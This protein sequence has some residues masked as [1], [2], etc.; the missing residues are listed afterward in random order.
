MIPI[1]LRQL[2][3]FVAAAETGTMAGG[4]AKCEASP[5]AVSMAIA[6]LEKRLRV[7]LLVRRAAKGVSLTEAGQRVFTDARALLAQAEDLVGEAHL[8]GSD[9]AGNLTVGCFTT[10][11]PFVVP[12]VLEGFAPRHP[13]VNLSI[14]E[15][16]IDDLHEALM[17]GQA[18][19]AVLYDRGL[20]A[21]LGYTV[22][23]SYRPY[24]IV[25]ATHRLAS[26][27]TVGLTELAEESLITLDVAPSL[28]NSE[29]LLHS[30]GLEP[31]I[32]HRSSSIDTVR[33]LVARGLG[34][35]ILVQPWP[36][37]TYAGRELAT[38]Q[39]A[40]EINEHHLVIAYPQ[41]VKLT[42]RAQAFLRFCL[43]T[44]P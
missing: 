19:C 27:A 31:R 22:I 43:Q 16:A 20:P 17:R 12:A 39:I 6:E 21:D 34:Y 11:A 35:A 1:S 25:A 2:E 33:S 29:E 28:Q 24:V 3:C 40:D 15:G 7:Q 10:L 38:L 32:G 14:L 23:R 44:L 9:I 4:A 18:E 41:G 42:R 37:T 30:A 13:R 26:R 36:T 5:S 8:A